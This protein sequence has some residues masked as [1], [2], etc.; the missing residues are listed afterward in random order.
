VCSHLFVHTV[1]VPRLG[2]DFSREATPYAVRLWWA[3]HLDLKSAQTPRQRLGDAL[4]TMYL[5]SSLPQLVFGCLA[6]IGYVLLWWVYLDHL[7]LTPEPPS[8]LCFSLFLS[9][10]LQRKILIEGFQVNWLFCSSSKIQ[11][12]EFTSD[13]STKQLRSDHSTWNWIWFDIR[14]Q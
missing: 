5:C 1:L 11:V 13:G 4:I 10:N 14:N 9:P 6:C 8:P 7:C 2:D 12:M 3:R